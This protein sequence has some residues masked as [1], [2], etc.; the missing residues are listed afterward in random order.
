VGVEKKSASISQSGLSL[1]LGFLKS[2]PELVV[3]GGGGPG[4]LNVFFE[5]RDGRLVFSMREAVDGLL[6]VISSHGED[7]GKNAKDGDEDYGT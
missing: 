7:R 6:K 3:S 4:R 1:L 5:K 2:L